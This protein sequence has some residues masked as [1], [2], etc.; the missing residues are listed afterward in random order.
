[1]TELVDWLCPRE[2]EPDRF[3][4]ISPQ[5]SWN[6]VFGGLVLSQALATCLRTA[7]GRTPHSLH[8]YFLL[9]G[10]AP[11]PLDYRVT[12]LRD[13]GSFT[14][15]RVDCFQNNQLIFSGMASFQTPEVGLHHQYAM[16]RVPAPAALPD[17]RQLLAQYGPGLPKAAHFWF[18]P[19][20]QIEI[21]VIDPEHYFNRKTRDYLPFIWM[22][23]K[24]RLPD[25]PAI[26][27][28]ALAYM[29]DIALIDTAMAAHGLALFEPTIQAASLDH[30][31]WLHQPLR[32]D[33]WLLYA[34]ESPFTGHS[35]GL[36]RGFIF[37]EN[38]Q[39]VASVTQE[40]LMRQ[41]SR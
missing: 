12:R 17:P 18:A 9:G 32:A 20:Q 10:E 14:T 1:M 41:R 3:I 35:R 16:P 33:E 40:G 2:I 34:P 23:V 30:G 13:G 8:A 36:S 4:G 28:A 39:L 29:S 5:T 6:R 38:G 11:T 22:R 25:D 26:H 31:L 37:S 21:R 19:E 24:H 7:P 15:R 27:Y